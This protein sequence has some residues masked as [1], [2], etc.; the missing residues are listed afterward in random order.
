MPPKS[1]EKQCAKEVIVEVDDQTG[2]D[3]KLPREWR[4]FA[5]YTG[6]M[7]RKLQCLS[8][9][10]REVKLESGNSNDGPKV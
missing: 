1:T 5:Q 4:H 9:R 2:N 6:R 7:S 8:S 10:Q 3:E